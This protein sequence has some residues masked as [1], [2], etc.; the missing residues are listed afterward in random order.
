MLSSDG[1][2]FSAD[3]VTITQ[4]TGVVLTTPNPILSPGDASPIGL[5]AASAAGFLLLGCLAAWQ[6]RRRRA[7][8]R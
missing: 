4:D 5:L 1:Q 3:S 6:L 8:N 2:E 7:G